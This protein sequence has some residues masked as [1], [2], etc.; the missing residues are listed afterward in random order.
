MKTIELYIAVFVAG[1]M[2]FN[3]LCKLVRTSEYMSGMD[4]GVTIRQSVQILSRILRSANIFAIIRIQLKR[5]TPR[6]C[7]S[8]TIFQ[9]QWKRN[10]QNSH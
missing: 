4:R 3:V 5:E 9:C 10:N 6:M 2:T 1:S 7:G 8:W